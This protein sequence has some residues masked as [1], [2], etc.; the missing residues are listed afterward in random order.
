MPWL[1]VLMPIYAGEATLARSLQSLVGQGTG[2]EVIAVD[3]ASPDRSRTILE[4]FRDRLDLTIIDAPQSRSWM[5]NTNIALCEARADIV[6]ML[7]QDDLWRP[8]RAEF[9]RVM[10]ERMPD[11][12]LWV[13]A[14]DYIDARDRRVGRIAPPFGRMERVVA[15]AEAISRLIVQNT[16]ALPAAAFR[17]ETALAS[18]GLDEDLWYTADWD[19]WLRLMSTGPVGW[20]PAPLAAYRLHSGALTLKG[21]RNQA[22]FRA[23]LE[24]VLNRYAW[25]VTG[26]RESALARARLA[27]DL[28]LALAAKLH[29]EPVPQLHLFWR[30]FSTGPLG[31]SRFISDTQIVSRIVARFR[32]GLQLRHTTSLDK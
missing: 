26:E 31:V 22:D 28:N 29:G 4:S 27:I 6:T 13:H 30:A 23:Q 18:G 32:A 11:A 17:R 5:Q 24:T 7:H 14:A 20:N 1:S 25:L 19:L 12:A 10:V 16:V 3:Q 9:L 8:G 15:T 2:I 21:S